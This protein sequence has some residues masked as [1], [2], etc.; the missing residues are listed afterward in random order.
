[1]DER[2]HTSQTTRCVG[3]PLYAE[4]IIINGG[5]G[6]G[7]SAIDSQLAVCSSFYFVLVSVPS[8]HSFQFVPP[9][10]DASYL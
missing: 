4:P 5:I 7:V 10:E 9:S 2:T 6:S 3:H 1:M 8:I